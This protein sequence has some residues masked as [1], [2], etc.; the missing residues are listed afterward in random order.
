MSMLVYLVNVIHPGT[1]LVG[2]EAEFP[3][4]TREQ[5]KEEKQAKKAAK[6]EEKENKR[7]QMEAKRAEKEERKKV[8]TGF[9]EE[10]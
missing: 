4:K 10:A 3:R 5:K 1:I 7:A 6:K 2:P 9:I 8:G